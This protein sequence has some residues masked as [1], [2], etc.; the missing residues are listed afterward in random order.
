MKQQKLELKV[1][2][3]GKHPSSSEYLYLGEQGAF[4]H[5]ILQWIKDGYEAF[6]KSRLVYN[7]GRVYNFY[8]LNTISNSFVCGSMKLSRDSKGRFYP[9]LIFV[10]I[11]SSSSIQLNSLIVKSNQ[12]WQKI[13]NI[14]NKKLT[15][16]EL[17]QSIDTLN[18]LDK[19][20][21][22]TSLDSIEKDVLGAFFSGDF[23]QKKLF[24]K[25]LNIDDFINL[26]R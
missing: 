12:I 22:Y 23:S 3:F 1:S 7:E 18:K 19:V 2:L 8:F 4:V 5:S 15:L 24:Y 13:S 16:E 26:M 9:L 14:F 11:P 25:T 17:K 10:E 6:L 21:C 20:V